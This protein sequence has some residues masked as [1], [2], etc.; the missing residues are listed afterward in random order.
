MPEARPSR[1]CRYVP[2]AGPR[3]TGCV[4]SGVEWPGG[5]G[6]PRRGSGAG[7]L[8]ALVD[9][10]GSVLNSLLVAQCFWS[11]LAFRCRR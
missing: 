9:S 4:A 8:I 3:N 7:V 6:A 5:G 1:G 2:A 11:P 10:A